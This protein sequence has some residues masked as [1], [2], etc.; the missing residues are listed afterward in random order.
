MKKVALPCRTPVAAAKNVGFI[1]FS[2]TAAAHRSGDL[3]AR[4][5]NNGTQKRIDQKKILRNWR[6]R[7][8]QHAQKGV[9]PPADRAQR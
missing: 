1:G 6:E 2:E 4:G 3:F 5:E 7:G 8:A 9:M